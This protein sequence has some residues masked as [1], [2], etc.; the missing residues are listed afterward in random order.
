MSIAKWNPRT[1][2][3]SGTP[4]VGE[5][6]PRI[7]A[8]SP[9]LATICEQ[10]APLSHRRGTRLP[11]YIW[12][13][14]IPETATDEEME[15]ILRALD[16]RGMAIF[17]RWNIEQFG[18]SITHALRVGRIQKRLGLGV[19]VDATGVTGRFTRGDRTAHVDANGNRYNS[20]FEGTEVGCP[21]AMDATASLVQAQLE[22]FLVL[23]RER[24][25]PLDFWAADWE[26]DGP[27]EWNEAWKDSQHCVRC[28]DQLPANATFA[29]YQR[30]VRDRRSLLQREVFVKNVK[31]YFVTAMVGNYA[32]N[33]HDGYRYWWDWFE[34]PPT[35]IDVA[36]KQDMQARHR[37][38]VQEYIASGYTVS[39]P[40]FYTWYHMFTDYTHANLQYRWFS[41]MLKEVS[42]TG[43]NIPGNVPSIPW[44]HWSTTNKPTVGVP[45][46]FQAMNRTI[47]K[48][49]LWHALLRGHDTFLMWSPEESMAEEVIPVH[50]VYTESLPFNEFILQGK[51]QLFDVP[52]QVGPVISVVLLRRQILVRRT[53]FDD[54]REPVTVTILGETLRIP[55]LDNAC[56]IIPLGQ[57]T[58]GAR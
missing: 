40:V 19:N 25:V 43:R 54:S 18:E 51:P 31:R 55:R 35:G 2:T 28:Q 13:A 20:K 21:F 24:G 53:D 46:D 29:D 52:D 22:A 1:A 48:E 16:Q 34:R 11:L 56:A 4:E 3:H 41:G 10:T 12:S 7:R 30:F 14:N 38:W 5:D 32:V 8:V 27:I 36:Y 37:P 50:E 44:V 6:L 39:M 57:S 9:I 49:L 26:V 17:S 23:Y 15:I 45:R 47:Y 42:S 33:P 58:I